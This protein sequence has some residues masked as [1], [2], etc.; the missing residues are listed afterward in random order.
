MDTTDLH[1]I[2]LQSEGIS[3]DTRA[4]KKNQLFFALKG[5]NFDGNKY[6]SKAIEQGAMY[7]IVDDSEIV[8]NKK[9]ILVE[10]VL[11][12]L[13]QLAAFHRKYL[14][15]PII[16]ITGTNG[17]TTTKELINAV[18][19]Q[20]FKTFATQ[21]NLNNHIG[22]P[23]TL[24]SM[25]KSTQLGIVEMGANHPGEIKLLASI[26]QP[27]FGL[28]T[29]IGTAHLEG[30]G[31]FEGVKKTKNELYQYIAKTGGKL[32]VNADDELLQ[33]L[34]AGIERVYYGKSIDKNNRFHIARKGVYLKVVW[35]NQPVNTRLV[36]DYNFYNVL[37]AIRVGLYFDLAKNKIIEA[38]EAYQPKN[39]RSQFVDTGKNK[40]IVDVYNANPVSMKLAIENFH[41][42]EADNKLLLLGDLLELGAVSNTEH[43]KI[44]EYVQPLKFKEACFIGNEFFQFAASYPY[45]FFKSADDLNKYL[46]KEQIKE[47]YV[48]LKAS[49]GI[50]LEKAIPYL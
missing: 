48:L 15:I 42:I 34:S 26:A 10:N 47:Y 37:A 29:N 20:K 12:T 33:E 27:D 21:G 9:Y 13:Q 19:R 2:F 6:A 35:N 24:L 17:K 25:N 3:T 1:K 36:G 14:N 43:Q 8:K 50:R 49:R 4:I 46:E 16:G 22:V 23:L 39:N 11:D 41:K 40:L 30:F 7:A 18:L 38:I 32:F 45:H 44:L 28:I 31:S 5:D